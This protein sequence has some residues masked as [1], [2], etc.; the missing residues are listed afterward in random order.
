MITL[1]RDF[2]PSDAK[3]VLSD[4]WWTLFNPG[5]NELAVSLW[6]RFVGTPEEDLAAALAEHEVEAG[7]GM[8]PGQTVRASIDDW[9]ASVLL[10]AGRSVTPKEARALAHKLGALT[11]NCGQRY[12]LTNE[13]I[14]AIRQSG[15]VFAILSTVSPNGRL[16]AK[17]LGFDMPWV[18]RAFFSCEMGIM[19][20]KS[21]PKPFQS[22][23]QELGADESSVLFVD[24]HIDY[25][26][27]AK[28]LGMIPVVVLHKNGHSA[29][30]IRQGQTSREDLA[31]E[32]I[33]VIDRISEIG[34]LLKLSNWP[35]APAQRYKA[36]K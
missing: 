12:P 22:A 24:D 33:I 11:A 30:L 21:N 35:P 4:L 34:E 25:V 7:I 17:N 9:M 16:A 36:A 23:C 26:R 19:K 3:V 15:R 20:E 31:A 5:L 32:K 2:R 29:T 1:Q 28:D 10:R 18:D 14:R 6:A 8:L 27:V 13:L